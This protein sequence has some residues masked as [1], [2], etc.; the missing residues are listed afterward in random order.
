MDSA[1]IP[2]EVREAF[3]HI[4]TDHSGSIDRG[5]LLAL[6]RTLQPTRYFGQEAVEASLREMGADEHGLISLSAFHEW[7]EAG[8][9]LTASEKL[10]KKWEEMQARFDSVLSGMAGKFVNDVEAETMEHQVVDDGWMEGVPSFL[11]LPP[12][13]AFAR[14][15]AA[16]ESPPKSVDALQKLVGV[17]GGLGA[18]QILLDSEPELRT[19]FFS[20]TLPYMVELALRLPELTAANP[21]PVLEQGTSAVVKLPRQVVASLLANMLLCSFPDDRSLHR[22]LEMPPNRT[23]APLLRSRAPQEVA[24]LRMF[25]HFFERLA[26]ATPAEPSG[27]LYIRRSCVNMEPVSG[28]GSENVGSKEWANSTAPLTT[29]VLEPE[30]GIE[31]A[32]G[33]LQ[34]DFANEYLGGGV[35][36]GGCVQEEIRF[37]VSP[38]CTVGLL[39]CPRMLGHEAIV[40]TGAEQFSCYTGY[41][42]SLRYGGDFVDTTPRAPDGTLQTAIV[43]IDAMPWAGS[44]ETQFEQDNL[45]RE[46]GKAFAGFCDHTGEASRTA[47]TTIATGNWGCG[48][49]GGFVDLKAV[50][51]WMAASMAQRQLR[52]Y[53][54]GDSVHGRLKQLITAVQAAPSGT[55]TVGWMWQKLVE[56]PDVMQAAI[57][58]NTDAKE[59]WEQARGAP[60]FI[61]WLLAQISALDE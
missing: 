52:Y 18:V 16:V 46:L 5:E 19:S 25:I 17:N 6:L 57:R 32:V 20:S 58:T 15:R 40:I 3:E 2:T 44:P 23:M 45:L 42:F 35:L 34:V 4:D 21:V 7:W 22:Q 51:Q 14:L 11:P 41:G 48:A 36:C 50:L 13:Q 53:P 29:L 49:F 54:F 59:Q 12:P 27:Y 47:F 31:D 26:Q 33:C 39:V 8:G 10:D 28:S 24:K 37:A 30:G 1:S 43:A 60:E 61:S 56:F 55:I 38:E 9:K